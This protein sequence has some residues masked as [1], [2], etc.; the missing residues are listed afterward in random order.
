MDRLGGFGPQP[1]RL[2]VG[3]GDP[4]RERALLPALSESGEFIVAERCLAADQLLAC[5]E[6]GQVDVALV[7]SGLHRLNGSALEELARTRVP[8][9]LLV[10]RSSQQPGEE[11]PGVTLPLDADHEAVRGALLAAL[12]GERPRT[13]PPGATRD[14]ALPELPRTPSP[15]P[16]TS[17]LIALASGHGSP[18]RTTVALN[19]A[20]A[21]GAV[22]PTVL[23]DADL[24]GPSLAAHLD[25]DPT[26]NLYMIAHAEPE[27]QRDWDRVLAQETQP[28]TPRSP[29]GVVLCGVPKPE[30]RVGLPASFLERLTAELCRRYRHVILDVGADLLGSESA[31][32]RA[33]LRLSRQVLLVASAD[34]VGLWHAR[35]VLGLFRGS[36]QVDL[37]R[38][39]LIINRHDRRY[40]HGRREIEWAL[41]VPTAAVIPYDYGAAQRAL[42]AQQPLVLEG[43]SR[44][45][46][47]LL[48]LAERVHGGSIVLPPEPVRNGGVW[49]LEWAAALRPGRSR[50]SS[51]AKDEGKGAPD[52]Q[53]AARAR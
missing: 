17:S 2:A 39:A 27:T 8:L 23:V 12:R 42:A 28:L 24:A 40:H 51:A 25:A 35:T 15:P 52:G 21:L 33:A 43:R 49:W 46:R 6:R 14:Q 18:G 5:L 11:L 1:L 36:L 41:G 19:L 7:A 44:A 50:G 53:Y 30:M 31:L 20:A 13:D 22:A 3:L 48:D 45:G 32:H 10:L 29:H 47:A 16:A 34:L 9:V 38:V 26:R 37:D 4:E